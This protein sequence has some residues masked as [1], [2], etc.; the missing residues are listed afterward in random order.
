MLSAPL[1]VMTLALAPSNQSYRVDVYAA[2]HL[3]VTTG[4]DNTNGSRELGG[5]GG[6]GVSIYLRRLAD[7]DAPP[8]L[9]AYLQRTPVLHLDAGGGGSSTTWNDPVPHESAS[10]GWADVSI[11]G[12][13]RW[14]HA[15]AHVGVAYGT[16]HSH[17]YAPGGGTVDDSWSGLTIPVDASLGV[18]WRDTLVS[19]GW[20]VSPTRSALNDVPAGFT[21]P[22]WGG[23]RASVTTV[24]QRRLFLDASVVVLENG[25]AAGGDVGLYPGRRLGFSA[26][27]KGGHQSHTDNAGGPTFPE[28]LTNALDYVG[29]GVDVVV[30]A[31]P[32]VYA[33]L[34]YDFE[35]DKHG[36]GFGDSLSS[37][38]TY[39]NTLSLGVG[40]RR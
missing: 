21:V 4:D 5:R 34:R 31:S 17:L 10:T 12:Y 11:S 35:W 26:G 16:G 19:V 38:V 32:N 18:R 27:I 8:S 30:W 40:F 3:D 9:Q 2:G 6:L 22:F 7:D 29:V 25:A 23:A 24:L 13:A 14:L 28:A 1:L 20:G 33:D 37:W 15:G 36:S 39:Y